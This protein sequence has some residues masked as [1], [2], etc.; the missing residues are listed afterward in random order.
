MSDR[1]TKI[2][3]LV[4]KHIGE[5]LT[6][7]ISLKPG[8]FVTVA[9]VD[10]TPDLRYTRIFVS[11]F[12]EKEIDYAAKT[13]EKELYQIQGALNKK[14]V[15]KPLPKIEFKIDMTESKADEIEKLLKEINN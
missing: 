9:K 12:P 3:S 1:I 13:L 11:I 2:N 14:L 5:I 15:M 10:T 7:D 4:Q 6:R 8:V